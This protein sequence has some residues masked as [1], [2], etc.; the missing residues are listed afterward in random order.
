MASTH[1]F[2]KFLTFVTNSPSL[3]GRGHFCRKSPISAT[4]IC[5]RKYSTFRLG[6]ADRSAA[7]FDPTVGCH[8]CSII[9]AAAETVAWPGFSS[10]FS[11]FT[12]PS[13]TS[14]E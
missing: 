4:D 6:A 10:T 9:A 12:T 8:S 3:K 5:D 14:I 7:R 1:E 13:S 2:A 11:D